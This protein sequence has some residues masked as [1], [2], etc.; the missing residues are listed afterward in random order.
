MA[1]LNIE[2]YLQKQTQLYQHVLHSTIDLKQTIKHQNM[3]KENQT[4]PKKYLPRPLK[5]FGTT[6]LNET[7]TMQY[8][9]LFFRHLKKVLI[10]N[11][12]SLELQQTKLTNI[13]TDTERQLT[14]LTESTD[15]IKQHYYQFLTNNNITT[16]HYQP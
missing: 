14:M 16:K 7:F 6:T 13:I 8:R 3:L 1:S 4:I 5:I 12:T 11:Q 10:H 9:D 2:T 15:K